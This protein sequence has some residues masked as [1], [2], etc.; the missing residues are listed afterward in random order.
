M[1]RNMTPHT[2]V[3]NGIS[4]PSSGHVWRISTTTKN[5]AVINYGDPKSPDTIP[6]V[7]EEAGEIDFAGYEP[8]EGEHYIVSRP[9]A[10]V[11][12]AKKFPGTFYVPGELVRNE[13]GQPIG[14]KNLVLVLN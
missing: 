14:C 11:L 12:V 6:V 1:I 8:T 3:V 9:M 10:T 4:I 7:T 13:A 2:I 5:V